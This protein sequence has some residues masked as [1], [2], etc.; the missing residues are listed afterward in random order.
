MRHNTSPRVIL[1]ILLIILFLASV[2]PVARAGTTTFGGMVISFTCLDA[3]TSDGAWTNDPDPDISCTM[4]FGADPVDPWT[5]AYW[6]TSPTTTNNLVGAYHHAGLSGI[7]IAYTDIPSFSA[8]GIRYLRIT[9][10][11]HEGSDPLAEDTLFVYRYDGTAPSASLIGAGLATVPGDASWQ[12]SSVAVTYATS[13]VISGLASSYARYTRSVSSWPGSSTTDFD[14]GDLFGIDGYYR[15]QVS[16]TDQAGNTTTVVRY[17]KIDGTPPTEPSNGTEVHGVADNTWQSLVDSPAFTWTVSTDAL[18]GPAEYQVSWDT[19]PTGPPTHIRTSP[20]FTPTAIVPNARNYL[21]AFS[22]DQLGNQSNM[23]TLF[24]FKYLDASQANG[25]EVTPSSP[26]TLTLDNIQLYLPAGTVTETVDVIL[27]RLI[28]PTQPL[29]ANQILVRAWTVEG[30]RGDSSPMINTAGPYTTTLTYTDEELADLGITD[31]STL[32]VWALVGGSWIEVTPVNIDPANNTVT[33]ATDLLAE[34]VLW[35][36]DTAPPIVTTFQVNGAADTTTSP[37]VALDI[38]ATDQGTGISDMCLYDH[39]NATYCDNPAHWRAYARQTAYTLPAGDGDKPVCGRVRD[40]AGNVSDATCDTIKLDTTHGHSFGVTID[41]GVLYTG[42]VTVT[43]SLGAGPATA[44]MCLSNDGAPPVGPADACWVPYSDAKTWYL[45]PCEGQVAPRTVY[46]YYQA[47][48]GIIN[49]SYQDDILLD[50]A[51]PQ[52]APVLVDSLG[53]TTTLTVNGSDQGSGL[54]QMAIDRNGM[55]HDFQPY[56]PTVVFTDMHPLSDTVSV[57]LKDGV[58]NTSGWFR[59]SYQPITRHQ[60]LPLIS[61]TAQ[62]VDP[63]LCPDLVVTDIRVQGNSVGVTIENQGSAP[64]AD[65]FWV[66]LYLN[67]DPPPAA[68]NDVWSDG[69]CAQGMVWGVSESGLPLYPGDTL[70]LTRDDAYYWPEY[71]TMSWPVPAGQRIYAQVD[72]AGDPAYGG[73]LECHE[74]DSSSSRYNNISGPVLSLSGLGRAP[75]GQDAGRGTS[76]TVDSLPLR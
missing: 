6:E 51:P 53:I 8:D 7:P 44:R 54:A 1:T 49:G 46:A 24:T 5:W 23:V 73:V 60:Y 70:T 9:L 29:S 28:S 40:V 30:V 41:D 36:P 10:Y 34:F 47:V 48:D 38:T 37:D 68:V 74:A 11:R 58:G 64:V 59:A 25:A 50:M 71:S 21:R 15:F 56:Q 16:G 67:P 39:P 61:R 57:R 2:S 72:S 55:I 18:N 52:A 33:F 31:E 17:L 4:V 35:G 69:R 45:A 76:T 22:Y 65:T 62:P 63:T 20:S 13:D 32:K 19:D 3:H 75:S 12:T 14:S 42:Q 66:D 43:L 26:V 27:S